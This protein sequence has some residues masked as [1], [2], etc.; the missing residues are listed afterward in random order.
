MFGKNNL[1]HTHSAT[2]KRSKCFVFSEFFTNENTA[3]VW[4]ET[5]DVST[6]KHVLSNEQITLQSTRSSSMST[7]LQVTRNESTVM[8]ISSAPTVTVNE[9]PLIAARPLNLRQNQPYSED[10]KENILLVNDTEMELSLVMQPPAKT[11]PRQSLFTAP[12][13]RPSLFNFTHKNEASI[14][15]PAEKTSGSDNMDISGIEPTLPSSE[16]PMQTVN[17]GNNY[18]DW[19]KQNNLI[20]K[21]KDNVEEKRRE[22]VC[23]V[24]DM[25]LDKS[26]STE[27]VP[28]IKKNE[29]QQKPVARRTINEQFEMSMD[30]DTATKSNAHP[31]PVDE[32]RT[33]EVVRGNSRR[34]TINQAQEMQLDMSPVSESPIV[35]HNLA[36]KPNSQPNKC[37]TVNQPA[38]MS[39]ENRSGSNCDHLVDMSIEI[40]QSEVKGVKGNPSLRQSMHQIQDISMDVPMSA[41]NRQVQNKA[42][43]ISLDTIQWTNPPYIQQQNTNQKKPT[44]SANR[45]TINEPREMSFD[46]TSKTTAQTFSNKT[47]LGDISMD[48]QLTEPYKLKFNPPHV[49]R[50]VANYKK[51]SQ[52]SARMTINEPREMSFDSTAKSTTKTFSNKTILDNMSMDFQTFEAHKQPT[53]KSVIHKSPSKNATTLFDQ[54]ESFEM[55]KAIDQ[56]SM[57]L[58]YHPLH[59]TKL[60]EVNCSK[61]P[62]IDF[63]TSIQTDKTENNTLHSASMIE[64]TFVDENKATQSAA[65]NVPAKSVQLFNQTKNQ[66]IRGVYDL[67]MSNDSPIPTAK[68]Y[69]LNKTP[70]YFGIDKENDPALI[71]TMHAS[72]SSLDITNNSG[73]EQMRDA[74]RK[75]GA[76]D[77]R[78]GT[79]LLHAT[80]QNETN[81]TTAANGNNTMTIEISDTS[82]E[83]PHTDAPTM[84][85]NMGNSRRKT[86]VE[87]MPM[88]LQP[89]QK[90]NERKASN[91]MTQSILQITPIKIDD[92]INEKL[93][94]PD[95]QRDKENKRLTTIRNE[96]IALDDSPIGNASVSF[97]LEGSK[98]LT[99]IDDDDEDD[100][101]CN[102]KLDLAIS[103][104]GSLGSD[105][106]DLVHRKN[107][108]FDR[109]SVDISKFSL[110]SM[111]SEHMY[112]LKDAAQELAEQNPPPLPSAMT[113][114]E[115]E[116][117]KK[118]NR[119]RHSNVFDINVSTE[120]N[121][122]ETAPDDEVFRPVHK[123]DASPDNRIS[124]GP[125]GR[126]SIL[127]RRS[128][129]GSNHDAN[130]T[131][132]L[133]KSVANKPLN[134]LKLNFSGYDQFI[135]LATPQDVFNDFCNRM[136]QIQ[137]K[138]QAWTEERRKLEN[139]EIDS[140]Y[141]NN[142]DEA[143]V[144][145]N[146]EAPS[147]A[148]LYINKIK[149]E[150]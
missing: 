47:N 43:D 12:L 33:A 8:D 94:N 73:D 38:E 5:Y 80:I 137:L 30:N 134:E 144:S 78:R 117:F 92:S 140:V 123:K 76:Q 37:L 48:L 66:S 81:T 20:A 29:L 124:M 133:S 115:L 35:Q 67:D 4:G 112:E 143:L 68:K 82:I 132:F 42:Q 14:L 118:S 39:L 22:T 150:E 70:F 149:W 27:V 56:N 113:L 136:N 24:M 21:P 7:T 72:G 114:N 142:N 49:Q 127:L 111:N 86:C 110:A 108:S 145:Q 18:R 107:A 85:S 93:P 97:G 91:I 99:F 125:V 98:Q 58:S 87:E 44:Q 95:S 120:T 45:M 62:D 1:N 90:A 10:Q 75:S 28:M 51:S 40:M 50:D 141:D 146:V 126:S 128:S 79:V 11:A 54:S 65:N 74:D 105:I 122:N 131:S 63:D 25:Y 139:G 6:E 9:K 61:F 106:N 119:L 16:L 55:T 100:Q 129:I 101:I 23:Q 15:A 104:D 103:L 17:A 57:Y 148:S 41:G 109:R 69:N 147:W 26:Q 135:G 96:T 121:P 83:L 88:V 77:L 116:A 84:F 3:I 53:R 34:Q 59:S 60:N 52:S 46:S 13:K 31:K 64:E 130:E 2:L 89:I 36:W 32:K 71:E 102:T 19:L 138:A